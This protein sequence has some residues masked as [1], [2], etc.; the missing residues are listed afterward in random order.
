MK[1]KTIQAGSIGAKLIND[2]IFISAGWGQ[3]IMQKKKLI[4]F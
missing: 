1:K 3:K 2:V 4:L